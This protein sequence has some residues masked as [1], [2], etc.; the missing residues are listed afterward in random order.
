MVSK[1]RGSSRADT[2]KSKSGFQPQG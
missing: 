1:G 2:G